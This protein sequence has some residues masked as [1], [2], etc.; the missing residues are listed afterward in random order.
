[1]CDFIERIQKFNHDAG[2]VSDG[3]NDFRESSMM[4][5]EAIEGYSNVAPC[6]NYSYGEHPKV[7][8]RRLA[9]S[10]V[11]V[12]SD[13]DRLD[14]AVDALILAV[15]AMTKL[16]LGRDQIVDSI[17]IVMTANETKIGCKK[18]SVG[19]LTKPKDFENTYAPEP[20]LQTILDNRK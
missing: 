11:G 15:G 13:V 9:T 8:A 18:D 19:K 3:Y 12:V 6:F 4:I 1:M 14:K 2:L 17:N 10:C 20:L 16:G 5:E 7:V